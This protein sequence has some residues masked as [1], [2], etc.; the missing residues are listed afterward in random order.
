MRR[1]RRSAERAPAESKQKRARFAAKSNEVHGFVKDDAIGS[2]ID[3]IFTLVEAPA[4]AKVK[5]AK[6]LRRSSSVVE[7]ELQWDA[8]E[9]YSRS[10]LIWMLSFTYTL[11]ITA[12]LPACLL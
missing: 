5:A 12:Y 9:D 1:S 7:E 10:G 2:E 11:F 4:A 6:P 8:A 3:K